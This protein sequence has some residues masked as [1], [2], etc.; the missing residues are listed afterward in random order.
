MPRVK[1]KDGTIR[2]FPY[3]AAGQAEAAAIMEEQGLESAEYT[4]KATRKVDKL[5][6]EERNRATNRLRESSFRRY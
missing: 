6:D 5:E 2:E 3:T 4:G 1:M